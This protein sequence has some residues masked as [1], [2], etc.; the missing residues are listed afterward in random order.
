MRLAAAARLPAGG[1]HRFSFDARLELRRAADESGLVC[2]HR[3]TDPRDDPGVTGREVEL[4]GLSPDARAARIGI[5]PH[6]PRVACFREW[7]GDTDSMAASHSGVDAWTRPAGRCGASIG[8][9]HGFMGSKASLPELGT[10]TNQ[11]LRS[12]RSGLC[13]GPHHSMLTRPSRGL[14]R[15]PRRM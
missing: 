9:P 8:V 1:V 6:G 11:R 5:P 15:E 14:T 2:L 7:Q 12:D 4:F 10:S 3:R 13:G